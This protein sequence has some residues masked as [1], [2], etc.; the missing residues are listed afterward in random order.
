M[1]GFFKRR[2]G[3]LSFLVI[4][5]LVAG[6]VLLT[7]CGSS[8]DSGSG[9]SGAASK[10]PSDTLVIGTIELPPHLD[11]EKANH[12]MIWV[13]LRQLTDTLLRYESIPSAT[14]EGLTVS[15]YTKL[16][17]RLAES[18]EVSDDGKTVTFHLKKGVK[19]AYGNEMTAK[20]VYYKWERGFKMNGASAFYASVMALP[21]ISAVK[22]ID[23]YTI[24]FTSTVPNPQ[25]VSIMALSNCTF[26]YDSTEVAKNSGDDPL[27]DAGTAYIDKHSPSFGPY[28]VTEFTPG[29]QAVL[30]ANPNYFAGEPQIKQIIIKVIPESSSR[31]AMLKDGTI[32]VAQEMSPNEIASLRDVEGVKTVE[33]QGFWLTH[34]VLNQKMV[35]E[36]KNKQ[37]RQAVNYAINRD[38]IIEMAYLGQADPMTS[39]YDMQYPG[40]LEASAFPYTYDIEKAKQL[41]KE[42]GYEKGFDIDLYY[43]AGVL[44]HE[45]ASVVIKE[46]L[47]KIGINVSLRKT[48][49]GTLE[50]LYTSK[51]APFALIRIYPF[52]PDPNYD[53]GL[54]YDTNGFCNFGYF[55]NKKIDDMIKEGVSIVDEQERYDFHKE[56][57]KEILAEA[58]VGFVVQEGYRMAMRSNIAG[59]NLDIGETT[60]VDEVT[61]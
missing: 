17:P 59:W 43:Q 20:D 23:D 21:D 39:V 7:G 56:I 36:F 45:T 9:D 2:V 16:E 13:F 42:A 15:E 5:V 3:A 8:S 53:V 1:N 18:H 55:S 57:Q 37:V 44:P 27:S 32:D 52:A 60:R 50:T 29:K 61:K 48:P 22:V 31:F 11:V 12:P 35:P 10:N 19:S 49:L 30:T 47:A 14:N 51:K 4:A 54:M 58:P 24:S 40:A 33:A 34:L 38:K 26:P 6:G 46:E 41:M 25:V 28:S